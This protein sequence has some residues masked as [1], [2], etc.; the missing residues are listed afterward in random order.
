MNF[1]WMPVRAIV[2]ISACTL[3]LIWTSLASAHEVEPSTYSPAPGVALQQSPGEVRLNFTEELSET[4]SMLQVFD[5]Q[6]KQVDSGDGGVDLY[7]AQHATLV[8]KLPVLT[9]GVYLVKWVVTLS[10]GD[11]SQGEYYFGVGNVS[12]PQPA[13]EGDETV[14]QSGPSVALWGGL[15]GGALILIVILVLLV[16]KFRSHK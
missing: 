9:E 11:A 10:D 1:S 7:D 13:P 3:S 12:V 14:A 5:A 8:V 4:G 2:L 16:R 15:V 6:G